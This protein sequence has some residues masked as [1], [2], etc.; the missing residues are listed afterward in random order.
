MSTTVDVWRVALDATRPPAATDL[1]DLS[2]WER[3]R[4][5]RFAS[6]AL[7]FR[8]LGAHAALR[9]VLATALDVPPAAITYATGPQGKPFL[10]FPERSG[11]EFNVSDS[12]ERALIAVSRDGPLGV[13][14]E[15]CRPLSDLAAV[16]GSHFAV[17]ERAHLFA[18]PHAEQHAAFYRIW[19]RKEAYLKAL[20]EGL[21]YGLGRFA[22]TMDASDA[23]LL[24]VDGD[25]RV[26]SP[27]HIVPIRVDDGFEACV[28]APWRMDE[29][30]V[31]DL[32]LRR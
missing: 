9:R 11:L 17:D 20:G 8:W 28:A 16:A 13:D 14:L 23:R 2:E 6:D 18:L 31:H 22:V 29:V 24:H 32:D 4:A 10:A 21:A 25:A 3:A 26:A 30:R 12:G 27:W 1:A 7:R 5:E 15:A 19:T